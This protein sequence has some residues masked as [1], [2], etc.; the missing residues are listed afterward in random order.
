M[1]EVGTSSV[2]ESYIGQ[3]VIT[4]CQVWRAPA[5]R[6]DCIYSVHQQSAIAPRAY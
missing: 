4:G 3:N 1:V 6:R 5:S 2:L